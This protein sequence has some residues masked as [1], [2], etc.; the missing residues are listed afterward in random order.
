M[1]SKRDYD[2]VIKKKTKRVQVVETVFGS[3]NSNPEERRAA[4]ARSTDPGLMKK[5][6]TTLFDNDA[7]KR[8]A[9]K[10]KK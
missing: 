3:M 5:R 7:K 8:A 2:K 4:L 1:S 9:K 6:A 10:R